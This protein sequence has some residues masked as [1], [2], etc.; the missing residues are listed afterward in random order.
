VHV[1]DVVDGI[2]EL[3]RVGEG[4]IRFESTQEP[5]LPLVRGRASELKEVLVNLLEN[6]RNALPEGGTVTLAAVRAGGDVELTV[7]D[8]GTGI[9]AELLPQVFEPHFSTRSGG[10]GLG[11]AI[12]RRLV[13][14]WGA[15]VDLESRPGSGT[16]VR[17]RLVAWPGET[18]TP[19]AGVPRGESAAS[20]GDSAPHLS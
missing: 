5:G 13:T 10:T 16:T 11:L 6:A 4:P 18:E 8:D 3:Y 17:L 7:R 15:S 1:P 2:L 12:V 14:S 20:G 19:A 9:P